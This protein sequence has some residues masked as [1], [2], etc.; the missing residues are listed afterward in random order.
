[1]VIQLDNQ[2]KNLNKLGYRSVCLGSYIPWDVRKQADII[3]K[4]LGWKGDV[5]EGMPPNMYEYEKNVERDI[6]FGRQCEI[7]A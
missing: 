4:E 1:M 7:S 3:S 2:V 6:E 5:V